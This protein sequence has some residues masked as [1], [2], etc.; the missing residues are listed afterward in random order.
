MSS[1][2]VWKGRSA[3]VPTPTKAYD[4]TVHLDDRIY[5]FPT[6]VLQLVRIVNFPFS[7][8]FIT[9]MYKIHKIQLYISF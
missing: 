5:K 3:A 4:A 1:K 7:P 9:T 2:T 6:V 8:H